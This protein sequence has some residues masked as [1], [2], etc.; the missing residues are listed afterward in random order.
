MNIVKLKKWEFS[1]LALSIISTFIFHML[2]EW[3]GQ[4]VLI[5]LISPV[6]ESVWEHGKLILFPF[7]IFSLVEMLV[8]KPKNKCNFFAVKFMAA[9]LGVLAMT[10]FFYLYSGILGSHNL[11]MDIISGFIGVFISFYFSYNYLTNN[12]TIRNCRLIN[13]LGVIVILVFFVFTFYPPNISWF[14]SSV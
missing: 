10:T 5:G 14:I 7:L 9:M 13:I 8:L 12:K 4:N 2:Y 11:I 1:I 3:L 6:N